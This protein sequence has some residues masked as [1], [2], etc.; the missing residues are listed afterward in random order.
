MAG[1]AE[2]KEERLV[3]I[4]RELSGLYLP[5]GVNGEALLYVTQSER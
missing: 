5:T 4:L 2:I 3:S 1:K